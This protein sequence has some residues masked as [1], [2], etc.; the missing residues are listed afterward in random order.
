VNTRGIT[1]VI[2][3]TVVIGTAVGY[4]LYHAVES[5]WAYY[6]SVDEFVETSKQTAAEAAEIDA[7]RIIRLGGRVKKGS[8][9][10]N[11]EKMQLDFELA[12]EK[13]SIA[14]RYYGPVPQ[15]FADDKEVLV[16]GGVGANG[17]FRANQILTR[18]E[19]KYKARLKTED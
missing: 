7:G 10:R 13:N 11:A 4:L 16:E 17:L 15:N 3:G 2:I 14:V 1:K 12:G 18:C 9:V 5:S 8:V 19:S 6:Y